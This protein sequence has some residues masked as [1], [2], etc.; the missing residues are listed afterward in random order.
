MELFDEI[1]LIATNADA[2]TA[3][4]PAFKRMNLNLWLSFADGRKGE[5]AVRQL[6]GG[7]MTAADHPLPVRPYGEN[8]DDDDNDGDRPARADAAAGTLP[9]AGDRTKRSS[10]GVNQQEDVSLS[11]VHRGDKIRTCDLVDPNHAL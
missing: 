8:N 5:R 11:K 7:L 1:D 4:R 3:M 6:C 9:A 2:R 10:A